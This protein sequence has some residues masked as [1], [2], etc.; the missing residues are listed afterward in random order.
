VT[1]LKVIEMGTSRIA[2]KSFAAIL[3]LAC[4]FPQS[5]QGQLAKGKSKFLG[6]AMD[7]S[8]ASFAT[9]WNQVTPGNAG[10]W[11]SVEGVMDSYNW[12][13]LDNVYNFA[14]A[15]SFKFKEHCLVWGSQQPG[16]ITSLDSASQRA[17][18]Q[19]W[20]QLVGAMYGRTSFVD[21]VNEPFHA[22]PLY[23]NALGGTGSTG[24]DW[25]ITAFAWARQSYFPGIKL[26][27]NEY[28]VLQTNS[29]T[30]NYIALI[31]TLKVRNLIDGIGIQGH[32]FE[33]KG[34][35]YTYD[36]N[37]LKANLNRLGA[38]GLP[39]YISEFD[40]NEPVDSVQQQNYQTYFPLFWENPAVK[41]MTLWGYFQG[42]VWKQDAYLV[43]LDGSERPALHWLRHYLAVP[44]RPTPISPSDTS[45]VPRNAT[46]IWH[47]SESA[48][49]YRVQVSTNGVFIPT[50]VDS[51]VTDTTVQLSPLTAN[52]I[53]YWHVSA[54]NDSG[55]SSY[56]EMTYFTTSDQIVAVE[57]HEP[58][59]LSYTLLQNFPNPFNPT[60][61]IRYQVPVASEVR[62]SV[63][64]VLGREVAVLVN[65]QKAPGMYEARFDGSGLSSGVYFYRMETEGYVQIKK[66]VLLR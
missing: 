14:V 21:V 66:L 39:I 5:G 30:D 63:Y 10:K 28:N 13:P 24:W 35:G 49:S 42:D 43:R 6:C 40:I 20:I 31:D 36:I 56:S 53:Y 18:V 8:H 1:I 25:V 37:T 11:G 46:L 9:Y 22:P 61:V 48:A 52:T 57:E 64:D 47:A 19:E 7:L 44:L 51:T 60:T 38:L 58:T 62:L 34:A 26:L 12:T 15:N 33:F 29:A 54:I 4:F 55:A 27:L 3:C 32:Y 17:Q 65:E 50:A 45:G 59:P 41:G 2:L 16:W 23:M